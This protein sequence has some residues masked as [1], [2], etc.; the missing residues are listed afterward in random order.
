MKL[1]RCADYNEMSKCGAQIIADGIS[2]NPKLV[3]GLATGSTPVGMYKELIGMF[4]SKKVDFS[5]VTTYNLDEYYPIKRENDQSYYFFMRKNL[6]D[7]I[8]VPDSSINLPNGEASDANAECEEY[9]NRIEAAG[10]IGIMV[11]G[12]GM[13]GHI[14]FNEPGDYLYA[15][16]HVTNLDESTRIANSRFFSSIDD[17]PA[18]ALTMGMHSI[19]SAGHCL[20]L[21]SGESKRPLL[22]ALLSGKITTNCPVT[23][24]NTVKNL[25]VITDIK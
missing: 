21:I 1:I 20:L 2:A 19:M 22:E 3:L 4:N 5:S 18:Q 14:G 15:K 17:V 23:L 12:V 10:G 16:T 24:L 6:F 13:N 9:E 7:Y 25:T 11:L 8:N